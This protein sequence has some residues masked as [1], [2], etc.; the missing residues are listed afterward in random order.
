MQMAPNEMIME[1]R[2]F[3]SENVYTWFFTNYY[4]EH[5]GNKLSD[6]DDISELDLAADNRIY[7]RPQL[8]NEKSARQHILKVNDLLSNPKQL[9]QQV[10]LSAEQEELQ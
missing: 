8:Y 10:E 5:A 1:V 3:L 6:F 4:L 9:H 2:E 7:M